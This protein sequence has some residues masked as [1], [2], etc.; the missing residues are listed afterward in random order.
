MLELYLQGSTDT[1]DLLERAVATGDAEAT[2]RCVHTLKSSSAQVGVLS[3][4][5]CA[6]EL[7]GREENNQRTQVEHQTPYLRVHFDP[8]SALAKFSALKGCRSS[9]PSPT[10]M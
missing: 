8:V 3:V 9:M 1:I 4:A 7:E 5:Q 2:L 6:E 10:P